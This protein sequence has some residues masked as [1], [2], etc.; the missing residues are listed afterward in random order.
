MTHGITR[1]HALA[2]RVFHTAITVDVAKQEI[3]ALLPPHRAFGPPV[4]AAD[5]VG[6]LIDRLVGV[7]D[8]VELWRQLLDTLGAQRRC[9]AIIASDGRAA[10]CRRRMLAASAGSS[11][12]AIPC[13]VVGISRCCAAGA[14]RGQAVCIIVDICCSRAIRRFLCDVAVIVVREGGR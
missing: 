3:A 13:P 2:G 10:R 8:L 12:D 11:R 6:K 4:V 14:E 5:T 7:D 1:R 9:A